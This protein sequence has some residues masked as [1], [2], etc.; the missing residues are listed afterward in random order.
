MGL[1][2]AASPGKQNRFGLEAEQRPKSSQKQLTGD[3]SV[4]KSPAP[5]GLCNLDVRTALSAKTQVNER[6][7]FSECSRGHLQVADLLI[8]SP[9]ST[10]VR[11]PIAT[12]KHVVGKD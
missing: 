6:E 9:A 3:T 8:E 12:Q 5:C 4:R 10:A 1:E 2:E 11:L 7:L